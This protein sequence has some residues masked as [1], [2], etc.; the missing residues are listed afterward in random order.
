MLS[1]LTHLLPA[2]PI[3]SNATYPLSTIARIGSGSCQQITLS[4]F[5][6]FFDG[7]AKVSAFVFIFH[8]HTPIN[9]LP[10]AVSLLAS[11]SI[12]AGAELLKYSPLIF[13]SINASGA[14]KVGQLIQNRMIQFL[15]DLGFS[16]CTITL[17]I[18]NLPFTHSSP[19]EAMLLK[20]LAPCLSSLI[21]AAIS[22]LRHQH[23]EQPYTSRNSW[24]SYIDVL[25]GMQAPAFT[26]LVLQELQWIPSASLFLYTILGLASAIGLYTASIY[27]HDPHNPENIFHV[28]KMIKIL[29]LVFEN[30]SYASILY[31]LIDTIFTPLGDGLLPAHI[32]YLNIGINAF[33]LLLNTISS[34]WDLILLQKG[35]DYLAY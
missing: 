11:V 10:M 9:T 16:W 31:F 21:G 24:V 28:E 15:A 13:T 26:L 1:N 4:V 17:I 8:I 25:R 33:Y 29:E 19:V 18:K 22:W 14:A 23:S 30:V 12:Y 2:S 35:P 3:Y 6:S 34:T 7:G 27:N 32:F 20:T 5:K